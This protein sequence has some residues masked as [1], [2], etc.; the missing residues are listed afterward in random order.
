MDAHAQWQAWLRTQRLAD[1]QGAFHWRFKGVREHQRHAVARRQSDE[2][3][4]RFRRKD[5]V[6]I[7]HDAVEIVQGLSLFIHQQLGITHDV[8]EKDMGNFQAQICLFVV[9]HG[10]V[11]KY[12]NPR[13]FRQPQNCVNRCPCEAKCCNSRMFAP[14]SASFLISARYI[15]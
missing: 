9:G 1:L 13:C 14:T 4:C 6:G 15:R 2:A 3:V 10:V 8:H 11:R 12:A 5:G 7:A